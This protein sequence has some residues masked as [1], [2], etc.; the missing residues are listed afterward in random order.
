LTRV[1]RHASRLT[2]AKT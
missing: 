2:I 1:S